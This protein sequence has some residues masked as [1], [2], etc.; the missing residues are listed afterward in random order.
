MSVI[1]KQESYLKKLTSSQDIADSINNFQLQSN[2]YR[3]EARLEPI[4]TIALVHRFNNDE[5][6]HQKIIE[7]LKLYYNFFS[8]KKFE[9]K[10]KI[11]TDLNESYTIISKN[12]ILKI[13]KIILKT[14][15]NV[16]QPCTVNL[17]KLTL[18]K[19][20]ICNLL[21]SGNSNTKNV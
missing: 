5:I 9:L 13:K 11:F 8:D 17:V 6:I 4:D 10:S 14:I 2:K 21:S 18:K 20:K 1:I 15:E 3:R 19:E 7:N 16:L 12:K